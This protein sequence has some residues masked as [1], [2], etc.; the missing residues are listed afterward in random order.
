MNYTN[1]CEG[2]GVQKQT[3]NTILF[4][5]DSTSIIPLQ[6][7]DKCTKI[8]EVQIILIKRR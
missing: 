5:V 8:F 6:L 7:C 4:M 1:F 3:S 2:L